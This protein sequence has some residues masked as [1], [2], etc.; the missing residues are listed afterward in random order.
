MD[1]LSEGF[2]GKKTSFRAQKDIFGQISRKTPIYFML[3][4]GANQSYSSMKSFIMG[5][6]V[7]SLALFHFGSERGEGGS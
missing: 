6:L 1:R 3:C 4:H 5:N 7:G 2:L